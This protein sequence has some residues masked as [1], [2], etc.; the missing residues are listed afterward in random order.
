MLIAG[1]ALAHNLA[2]ATRNDWDLEGVDME[3]AI[4]WN[5]T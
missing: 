2:V 3:A 5:S 4:P 1:T